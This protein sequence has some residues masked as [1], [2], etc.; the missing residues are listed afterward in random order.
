VFPLRITTT[1][2]ILPPLAA[3]VDIVIVLNKYKYFLPF[4]Q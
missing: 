4:L 1:I 2:T 3:A